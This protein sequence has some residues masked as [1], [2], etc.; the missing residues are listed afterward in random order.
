[1]QKKTKLIVVVLT[2]SVALLILGGVILALSLTRANLNQNQTDDTQTGVIREDV[3]IT[4]DDSGNGSGNDSDMDIKPGIDSGVDTEPD[5]SGKEED[6]DSGD[7]SGKEIKPDLEEEE[8]FIIDDPPFITKLKSKQ[9][10]YEYR[11]VSLLTGEDGSSGYSA[12]SFD[13]ECSNN[14]S[15]DGFTLREI[16]DYS[17]NKMRTFVGKSQISD[18]GAHPIGIWWNKM[19]NYSVIVAIGTGTDDLM[20]ETLE[21]IDYLWT[22]G[23]ITRYFLKDGDVYA[24]WTVLN[25]DGVAANTVMYV[26]NSTGNPSSSYF[27]VR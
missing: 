14:K 4:G 22:N 6:I 10:Y 16:Y 17:S 5:K 27:N 21:Y 13:K 19:T 20:G 8:A 7:D 12:R 25:S 3:D 26:S 2:F 15:K 11:N 1:M 18:H 23:T 9:F 24:R